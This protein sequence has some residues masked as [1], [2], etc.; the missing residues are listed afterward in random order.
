[1]Y[2]TPTIEEFH[3]GFEYEILE[4][5]DTY[6]ESSWWPQVYGRNGS[7]PERLGFVSESTLGNTRVKF[8]DEQDIKELGWLLQ[9]ETPSP[10]T[11]RLLKTFKITKVVGFNTGSDY[12]LETTDS[13]KI[14][15][16]LFEYSSYGGGKGEVE[17]LVKNKSELKKLMSQLGIVI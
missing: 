1:M 2:Y 10:F 7:N 12:Y 11:G 13:S 6:I 5:W 15:I 17:V 9:G 16:T 8:L 14:R 3:V 4:N